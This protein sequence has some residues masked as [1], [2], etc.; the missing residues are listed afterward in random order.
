[1]ISPLKE[2]KLENRNNHQPDLNEATRKGVLIVIGAA[3]GG[4]LLLLA[5]ALGGTYLALAYHNASDEKAKIAAA[6]EAE[7]K[8]VQERLEKQA[9]DI[10]VSLEKNAAEDAWG[11]KNLK[12]ASL[13][14]LNYE[15][16]NR[17]FP[18]GRTDANLL[19]WR[20]HIL[21]YVGQ[22]VLY[23]KFHLDEPWD[24]PHNQSLI[25]YMPEVYRNK[26]DSPAQTKTRLQIC[27][28]AGAAYASIGKQVKLASI[29]DGLANTVS[30][31]RLP[32][33]RA[34]TWTKPE[35]FA[36]DLEDDACLQVLQEILTEL[37]A[38]QVATF[39]A[40]VHRFS[41][42]IKPSDFRALLTGS[43]SELVKMHLVFE[44]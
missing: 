33:S 32:Q 37:P 43:G 4:L 24:S 5:I 20:V 27:V 17:V 7:A 36:L 8:K 23:D 2:L 16:A 42:G 14:M 26:Y 30:I 35:D 41:T 29:R 34:V 18:P 40:G 38:M 21:P 22:K 44:E 9:A 13:G 3:I 15:S 10:K 11:D 31:M 25:E 1:M 12:Y 28:G 6:E 39:D 19:S